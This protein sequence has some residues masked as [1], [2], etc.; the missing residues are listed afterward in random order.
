MSV[1]QNGLSVDVDAGST[2]S[3]QKIVMW[4]IMEKKDFVLLVSDFIHFY[5]VLISYVQLLCIR[6]RFFKHNAYHCIAILCFIG[7]CT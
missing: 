6:K 1:E 4:M 7:W 3:V 5:H 2:R